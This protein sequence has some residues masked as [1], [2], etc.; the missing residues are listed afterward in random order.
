M[1]DDFNQFDHK[2]RNISPGPEA[3]D[4][5]SSNHTFTKGHGYA[6]GLWVSDVGGGN[7][8]VEFVNEEQ[9]TFPVTAVGDFLM[10]RAIK[11]VLN[12]GTDATVALGWL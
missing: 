9:Y 7:V 1:S 5:S 10:N 11:K 4:H 2:S 6:R 8:A 3:V 12:S